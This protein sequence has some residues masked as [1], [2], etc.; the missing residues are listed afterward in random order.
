MKGTSIGRSETPGET[1]GT[2]RIMVPLDGRPSAESILPVVLRLFGT[3]RSDLVL[4]RIAPDFFIKEAELVS[5]LPTM[6]DE[7]RRYLDRIREDLERLGIS[8]RCITKQGM[9]AETIL[10]VAEEE[11]VDLIAMG[12]HARYLL[13]RWLVGSVADRV[14]L[15]AKV[16]VL[17]HKG[18]DWDLWSW[19][20]SLERGSGRIVVPLDGSRLA[21]EAIPWSLRI[22]RALA[23]R[24]A[25][26]RIV[27]VPS[28]P[29]LGYAETRHQAESEAREYLARIEPRLEGLATVHV[30]EG[31]PARKI[32]SFADNWNADLIVM[33][34]HGRTG[35]TRLLT[36]SVADRVVRR[37]RRAILL[38]GQHRTHSS[39]KEMEA[40]AP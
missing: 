35:L 29:G 7:A 28:E 26:L 24:V 9:E 20:N 38:V 2:P 18:D 34:S 31:N 3:G 23:G 22:A 1:I 37:A 11:G 36:G 4:V 8:P 12:T 39:R 10:A 17:L 27:T 30:D 33:T 32:A 16:P 13:G 15:Q 40:Q 25:L 6:E 14:R 19:K 5:Q 21:E